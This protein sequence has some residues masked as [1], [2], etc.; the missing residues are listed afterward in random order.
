MDKASA[1]SGIMG[2]RM[3]VRWS[4]ATPA[5]NGNCP[6]CKQM[7]TYNMENT[8]GENEYVPSGHIFQ[9]IYKC[10]GCGR[11]TKRFFI[12]FFNKNIKNKDDKDVETLFMKKIGQ[13]PAWGIEVDKELE[14]V[15]GN[16]KEYYKKGL[17]CESQSYGIGA[18]AYYR[19]ITEDIIDELLNSIYDL[20]D[21]REKEK[22]KKALEDVAKT[23][24]A[25]KKIELVKDLLPQSLRPEDLNPLAILHSSLSVGLH[26]QSDNAC[27]EKADDIKSVLTFLVNQISKHKESSTQFTD[28]MRK[29]LDKKTEEKEA[30]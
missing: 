1:L 22:Y 13:Y 10:A 2:G 4:I 27:L 24:V 3:Y 9:L 19:R 20:I 23:R 7:Q 28:S 29:L 26:G 12:Y 11:N 30:E 5:I 6:T 17:I 16:G 14:K 25:S 18:Y 15:L 8:Y 21:E